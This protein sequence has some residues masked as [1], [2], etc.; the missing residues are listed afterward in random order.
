MS[1][2]RGALHVEFGRLATARKIMGVA[3][4]SGSLQQ[5]RLN[6]ERWIERFGGASSADDGASIEKHQHSVVVRPAQE[7]SDAPWVLYIHGGGLVYYSTDVFQPFLRVLSNALHAPVEAFDYLKAPEHTAQQSIEQLAVHIAERCEELAGRRLVLV[8]DSVGGLLTLYLSLRVLPEVFSRIL[9][10]YPVLD[11]AT[12][13]ESY[14]TFGEG[15]FLDRAAMRR[16]AEV[17]RPYFAER[18]FDPFALSEGDLTLLPECSIVTAGCDVLR[19]EG[20]AWVE[21]LAERSVAAHHRHFPDLPHDFC[22]YAAKLDSAGRAVAEIAAYQ[23]SGMSPPT[24]ARGSG[25]AL[26][27][28]LAA[29][30]RKW[31][32]RKAIGDGETAYTFAELERGAQALAAWLTGQGVGAGDRVAVLADKRAAMP[33]IAVAVWK[34]GAVYAPL[35]GAEPEPRLRALLERLTPAV[36]IALDERDPIGPAEIFLG[37]KEL[38]ALLSEP[39]AE[40]AAEAASAAEA[41]D[42]E[43]AT[44][45]MRPTPL[46]EPDQ[47]A[48]IIWA[49]SA[50][51]PQGVEISDLSLAASFAAH[52]QM[53]RLT[54]DSRVLSLAPFHVDVSLL[55]TLL[56]LSLG[57]YVFQFRALPAGAVM[58]SVLARE[59]ISHLIAVSML[60]GMITGDGR[61]I[62]PAK[63]P[64]LEVVLTG[65]Q[66]CE[67]GVVR[68]WREQLPHTRFLHA[69][70][71]PEATIFSVGNEIGHVDAERETAYPIG[72]PLPGMTAKL[73]RE[74]AEV[75]EPDVEAELWIAGPQVMRG[76]FDRPEQTARVIAELDGTRYLRTGDLCSRDE[77]GALVFRRHGDGQI[78]WLAGRRTHLGE[79]SAAALGRPGVEGAVTAL[80]RRN[81]RDVVAL[82]IESA[83]RRLLADVREHLRAELPEYMRPTVL[84]WAP[85]DPAGP[86]TPADERELI[87]R[88]GAAAQ[89]ANAPFFAISADGAVDPIDEVELCQQQ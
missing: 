32:D 75:H 21:H 64:D 70:G 67:P 62:T 2:E 84:A 34:C 80:I 54:S 40:G 38:A 22:L 7:D 56:P 51:E 89:H 85:L 65:A 24:D 43:D 35:D 8:G 59:K 9:L 69:F 28:L 27:D 86:R 83:D 13:R 74:G 87:R 12:E 6:A 23:R 79:I 68:I 16:F 25:V 11:L 26:G 81:E 39:P 3:A 1:D 72:R 30:A 60:L 58:R 4:S 15:Y 14:Q 19:D 44:E 63:L 55:D 77:D 10:I 82:V 66:V 17:L 29:P 57:A 73:V 45:P 76:Y 78:G 20:L 47:A 37:G 49:S 71:P 61:Q 36:V 53:L 42:A 48:Y 18:G 33:M 50:S 5:D 41:A 46:R 88:L 52:Q 31:P